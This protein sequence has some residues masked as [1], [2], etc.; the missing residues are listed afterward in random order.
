MI[1]WLNRGVLGVEASSLDTQDQRNHTVFPSSQN[2]W[3][4]GQ[5]GDAGRWKRAPGAP[6]YPACWAPLRWCT[7]RSTGITWWHK[8]LKC[9]EKLLMNQ[10]NFRIIITWFLCLL[11]KDNL[12]CI[13]DTWSRVEKFICAVPSIWA[14]YRWIRSFIHW[15]IPHVRPTCHVQ[16]TLEKQ[17]LNLND[18]KLLFVPKFD[19]HF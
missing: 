1:A 3:Q 2:T 12:I 13:R 8:L 19:R 7:W 6:T 4:T 9:P 18:I 11:T 5:R 10:H 14:F 15:F 17:K 16:G